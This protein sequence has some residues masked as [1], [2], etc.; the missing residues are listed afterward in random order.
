MDFW[1]M[2]LAQV[3]VSAVVV[4]VVLTGFY[5]IILKPFLNKKV[6]EL[7][8]AVDDIEPRISRGVKRG[9][10]EALKDI[11][12]TAAKES[13]RQFLR[14]GSDL[15]ENGLSSFIGTAEDLARRSGKRPSGKG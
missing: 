14:F 15:F 5:L 6:G 3:A 2:L 12:E 4:F 10:G 7:I 8:A 13:T 9:V 11:P 1:Q